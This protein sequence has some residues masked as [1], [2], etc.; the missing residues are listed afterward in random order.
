M[1]SGSK[2]L[3]RY[4]ADSDTAE[5]DRH[6]FHHIAAS[7][8]GKKPIDEDSE[9]L[10]RS[11]PRFLT[12]V[13]EQMYRHRASLTN[14]EDQDSFMRNCLKNL[15]D[16]EE[17]AREVRFSVEA[18]LRLSAKSTAPPPSSIKQRKTWPTLGLYVNIVHYHYDRMVWYYLTQDNSLQQDNFAMPNLRVGKL[19]PQDRWYVPR[20][21]C[22]HEEAE[23]TVFAILATETNQN[24]LR[25]AY[26][27]LMSH[28][29]HLVS[30]MADCNQNLRQKPRGRGS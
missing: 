25:Y 11:V 27:R 5:Q 21:R 20:R 14:P 3:E 1:E 17:K 26:T 22:T 18:T 24:I 29:E 4:A 13:K 30:T 6:V 23:E 8:K 16:L 9:R 2:S 19:D 7:W 15:V 10:L 12:S 28:K